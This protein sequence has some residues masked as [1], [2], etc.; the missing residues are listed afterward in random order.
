MRRR[1]NISVYSK[2]N[3]ELHDIFD[4]IKDDL[5]EGK[6]YSENFT[7]RIYED[8]EGYKTLLGEIEKR[9]LRYTF[10]EAREY[11][12][13]E[14]EN[15][16][17]YYSWFIYP[18][19]HAPKDADDFGTK[20]NN[21]S[22]CLKCGRVREQISELLIDMKK[23]IKYKI[24]TIAPEIF[25]SEEIRNTLEAN[26]ISGIT[27][28]EVKDYKNREMVKY[29]QL[30]VNN[31]LPPMSDRIRVEMEEASRCK[32]CGNGGI[33]LRSEMIYKKEDLVDAK[34]F[35]LTKEYLWGYGIRQVVI[36]S[37]VRNLFREH[38]CRVGY[39]PVEII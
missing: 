31:I 21:E 15:A 16:E 12:K 19:Q 23:I 17:F 14:L 22:G 18:W 24:G 37:K 26:N 5:F 11:T 29:Y 9:G 39:E 13:Q 25:V 35:N 2:S 4:K 7:V 28:G 33:Y 38:K 3:E 1:A 10:A 34:D 6:V 20:Y 36:S 32:I 30:F 8:T 27:F